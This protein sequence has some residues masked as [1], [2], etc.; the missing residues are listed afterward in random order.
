MSYIV[1]Q[2]CTHAGKHFKID[3]AN[4]GGYISICVEVTKLNL[5]F[6]FSQN[7]HKIELLATVIHWVY[8]WFDYKRLCSLKILHKYWKSHRD[9]LCNFQWLYLDLCK[10]YINFLKFCYFTEMCVKVLYKPRYLCLMIYDLFFFNSIVP[11][12]CILIRKHILMV[13]PEFDDYILIY[14][15]FIDKI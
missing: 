10:C 14:V 8:I 4:F 6:A 5:F 1:L 15:N 9:E 7:L 13:Y 2:F 3:Y 12:C 11:N